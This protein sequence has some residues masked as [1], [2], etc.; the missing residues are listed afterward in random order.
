MVKELKCAVIGGGGGQGRSWMR[1]LRSW[2]TLADYKF[3]IEAVCDINQNSLNKRMEEFKCKGYTDY[4][5]MFE[6]EKLDLVV[7]ATPH[8]MHAPMSIAAAEHGVN[9]LCEKIMCINLKQ[10]DE[11]KA[12]VEKYKIKL[13]VGF[14][15]RYNPIF[16]AMRKAVQNGDLGELF[17]INLIYHWWRTEDYYLNSTPVPENKDTDWEGWRGH[18]L[19][20]GGGA[21]ANQIVHF[22]DA[23]VSMSQSPIKS[24][25][26]QSKVAKH[27]FV[28]TD[29]NTNAIVEFKNDSMGLI[30]AG[31]A[32]QHD[33]IEE[34][35]L[36]GI[37]G[38]LA[39]RKKGKGLMGYL[40]I[41]E[42]YRK[43][44]IKKKHRMWS[45]VPKNVLPDKCMMENLLLAIKNDDPKSISVDVNEGRKTVEILRA[46]LLS[47][48]LNKKIEFPFNDDPS[49]YPELAHPYTAPEFR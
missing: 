48:A 35:S 22:I 13:A 25:Y 40:K 45:Y 34:L 36:F 26:A 44:E 28:E 7:I 39:A 15:H 42:D 8:Y 47:Q 32:Y 5:E 10:A 14:Q 18:W 33:K 24:L 21:I 41:F 30:Q 19:T 12:A 23:F 31:V 9:V 4:R 11:M 17:Q 6:K 3:N 16:V 2:K 1:R 37:D 20:E 46:I 38:A 27:T 43:A 29:D 49:K